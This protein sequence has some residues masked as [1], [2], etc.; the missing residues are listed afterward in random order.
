[1]L[2]VPNIGRKAVAVIGMH[3]SGKTTFLHQEQTD[4]IKEIRSAQRQIYSQLEANVGI[5]KETKLE[6]GVV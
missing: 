1:M 3:R 6:S 2:T 4:R 5:T